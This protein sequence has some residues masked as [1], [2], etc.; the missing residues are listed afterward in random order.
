MV[1]A[2]H[3]LDG[4]TG[5]QIAAADADDHEHIGAF[6]DPV[7]G[8]LDTE[9]LLGGLSHRQVQPAQKIVAGAG[10][11]GEGAVGSSHFLLRRQQ[12]R[13]RELTP[14][15]GNINFDHK[16]NTFLSFLVCLALCYSKIA[17]NARGDAKT[18]INSSP[19]SGILGKEAV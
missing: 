12:L 3:Q 2:L 13:Q 10:L 1:A 9:H 19:G 17:P 8:G 16:G 6:P 15:I 4:G 14:Y 5:A 18:F 7:S 11:L